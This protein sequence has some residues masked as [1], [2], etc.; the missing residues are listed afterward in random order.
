MSKYIKP[1]SLNNPN[2]AVAIIVALTLLFIIGFAALAIDVAHLSVVRNELQNAADAGALAGARVL[3]NNSGT[4][5]NVG[6]NQEAYDT[7]IAN[8][9]ENVP[10]EINWT[11]GNSGDVQRGHWS[12]ATKTFTPN[13]STAPVVLW[14]RSSA[15]LDADPDFI[16]AVRVVT[17]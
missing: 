13:A 6:A 4:S 15:E 12:F 17:R 3:Y 9:S 11:G 1:S 14:N 2:G 16:N 10:V 5:V 7:G 8:K